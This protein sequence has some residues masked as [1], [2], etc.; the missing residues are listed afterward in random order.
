[1]TVVSHMQEGNVPLT[2]MHSNETP[3]VLSQVMTI[4]YLTVC[5]LHYGHIHE[6]RQLIQTTFMLG[7]EV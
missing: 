5:S 1:M 3:Y 4:R 2:L 6:I 7:V